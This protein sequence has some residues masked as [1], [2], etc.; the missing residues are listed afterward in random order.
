VPVRRSRRGKQNQHYFEALHAKYNTAGRTMKYSS[1]ARAWSTFPTSDPVYRALPSPPLRGSPYHVHGALIARLEGLEALIDFAYAFWAK[2][3]LS[4][5]YTLGNWQ[6]M[7]EYLKNCKSKWQSD[8]TVGEKE[9]AL[10]SIMSVS[11]IIFLCS[12]LFI[13]RLGSRSLTHGN[14]DVYIA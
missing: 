14:A 12:S 9:K 5:R 13:V 2:D 6:S 3:Y 11:F 4:N 8:D 1:Q 7:W 10:Y